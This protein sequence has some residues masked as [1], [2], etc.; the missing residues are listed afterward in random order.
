MSKSGR[1]TTRKRKD[2]TPV[3]RRYPQRNSSKLNP[4]MYQM[5]HTPC[6]GTPSGCEFQSRLKPDYLVEFGALRRLGFPCHVALLS[7][8]RS[9]SAPNPGRDVPRPVFTQ[10][11]VCCMTERAPYLLIAVGTREDPK[12]PSAEGWSPT[13]GTSCV[14]RDACHAGAPGTDKAEH[15][16]LFVVSSY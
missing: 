7:S 11:C 8:S 4:T 3:S 9:G 2:Y 5:N 12:C 14:P 6:E 1:R 16:P 15:T 13:S 10:R